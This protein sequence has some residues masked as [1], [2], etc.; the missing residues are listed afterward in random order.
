MTF[1]EF[2]SNISAEVATI[3]QNIQ[4]VAWFAH[5]G[6]ANFVVQHS[7]GHQAVLA[8]VVIVAGGIKEFWFDATYEKDPPQTF[9]DNFEDWSGWAA[10]AILGWILK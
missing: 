6:V 10:G 1:K 5:A 9:L 8:I 7:F 2:I 3:G 4:F